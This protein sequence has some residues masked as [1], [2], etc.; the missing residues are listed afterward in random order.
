MVHPA[1]DRAT[2]FCGGAMSSVFSVEPIVRSY[3]VKFRR[4]AFTVLCFEESV[5]FT[6]G[7]KWYKLQENIRRFKAG[8]YSGIFSFGGDHSNHIAALAAAGTMEKIPVTGI[9]RGERASA[10]TLTLRRAEQQGMKLEFVSRTLYR[11]LRDP[12]FALRWLSDRGNVYIIPEGG[13]NEAGV[14]GCK[15]MASYIPES[16]TDAWL[17]VGTGAT[18][19]GIRQGLRNSCRLHGVKVVE[20]QQE[21]TIHSLVP[22]SSGWELYDAFIFGG[23]ARQSYLLDAFVEEWNR[24][25][26][27]KI[28]PVYT[29]R[30]FYAAVH[31]YPSAGMPEP[32]VLMHTGGLQYC[33][34]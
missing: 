9:I 2:G 27:I 20:A 3:P 16:A 30:V 26:G 23:Y 22:D 32:P 18:L 11:Q 34:D 13:S 1:G 12:D 5:M 4:R 29:G 33:S 28:E 17:A 10:D 21:K 25:T 8:N 7:N 15:Q 31:C 14:T 24:E 6:G 19:S